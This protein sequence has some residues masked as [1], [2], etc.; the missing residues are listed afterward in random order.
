MPGRT[1]QRNITLRALGSV[2][3]ILVAAGVVANLVITN[4]LSAEFDKAML[5]KAQVLVTLFEEDTFG[6]EFEFADE[7]MPEFGRIDDPE[8]FQFRTPE[9]E[10]FER[11]TQLMGRDLPF[12]SEIGADVKYATRY[13]PMDAQVVFCR[14]YS[15]RSL[16]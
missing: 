15:C 3:A 8:Y 9:G 1:I 16:N 13:S 4:W 12:F 6:M 2:A 5:T 11:S 7:V 10:N 14:W